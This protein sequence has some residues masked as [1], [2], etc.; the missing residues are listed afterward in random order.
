MMSCA[1]MA[2]QQ[3][4][5]STFSKVH[6][7]LA[8]FDINV[9]RIPGFLRRWRR[10]LENRISGVKSAVHESIIS[11]ASEGSGSASA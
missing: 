11:T 2:S 7:Y 10:T 4:Y 8:L 9:D 1:M 5:G 3:V 6:A